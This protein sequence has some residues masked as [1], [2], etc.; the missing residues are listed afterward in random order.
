MKTKKGYQ[1]SKQ[2]AIKSV[3]KQY[4]AMTQAVATYYVEEVLGYYAD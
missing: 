2:A 3:M 1:M 4:P